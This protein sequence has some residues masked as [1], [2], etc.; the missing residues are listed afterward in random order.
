MVRYLHISPR[1]KN[2]WI[3]FAATGWVLGLSA[4]ALGFVRPADAAKSTLWWFALGGSLLALANTRSTRLTTWVW[5]L[6]VGV[7]AL[8]NAVQGVIRGFFGVSPQ[9]S[10]IAEALANTNTSESF[11]FVMEQRGPILQGLLYA[12]VMLWVA[13]L[14]H[15]AWAAPLGR[16]FQ[17]T[18]SWW[19]IGGL[20]FT[21]LLHLNPSMLRQQPLMRWGV[22]FYRHAQAQEEIHA[23]ASQ[24]QALWNEKQTW[25]TRLLNPDTPRTVVVLIGESDNRLNWGLLGYERD[26]TRPLRETFEK[27]PGQITLFAKAR[28]QQAFTLPSLKLALTPASTTQPDL[29]NSTPDF[30]FLA[31]AAGF[32]VRWLSNQPSHE[33]WFSAI[34]QGA[35]ERMFINKGN[36]R[37]SS[38]TDN[39]L[40]NPLRQTLGQATHAHELIVVHLMGQHFHYAQRCPE[41]EK[42]FLNT[43]NDRVMQAMKAAGRSSS[44]RQSRN[45]YDNA[46]HCGARSVANMLEVL[47]TARGQRQ[48]S[49]LYFSDHGQEV[50]HH[51]DFAGHSEQDDSGYTIPVWLWRNTS[52]ASGSHLT[53]SDQAFDLQWADQAIHNLLGIR[54][55]WYAPDSDPLHAMPQQHAAQ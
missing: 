30:T 1:L 7:F 45:E 44:I 54:S 6:L 18:T 10:L 52:Q 19:L 12:A 38:A 27:L 3:V 17:Q 8:D 13:R 16:G 47:Q 5:W 31:K 20:A 29:W 23:L 14:G 35:D 36:W 22:V 50:G 46:V 33:G 26:T 25:Q 51:R 37:D 48:L 40:I 42:P 15:R 55:A 11:G 4:W 2:P 21:A 43:D 32:H 39:D 53:T 28:S 9:P 41:S 24:R 34:A 49:V